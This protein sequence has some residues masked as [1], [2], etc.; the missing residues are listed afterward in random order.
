MGANEAIKNL[1]TD[2]FSDV[3]GS[4][5]LTL[6]DFWATWCGPCKAIAPLLEELASDEEAEVAIGKVDV[7]QQAELA[8]RYAVRAIPT[9][10]LFRGGEVIGQHVGALGRNELK[11]FVANAQ[12]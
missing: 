3:I 7:D 11:D 2:N 8:Q 10:V 4:P 12:Q 5:G 1:D 6:V 9:L